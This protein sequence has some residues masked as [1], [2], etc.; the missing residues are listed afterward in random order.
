MIRCL[1]Y[2]QN[3]TVQVYNLVL[4][5]TVEGRIFLLLLYDYALVSRVILFIEFTLGVGL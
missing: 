1:C 5:D 4:S 3:H 2:G